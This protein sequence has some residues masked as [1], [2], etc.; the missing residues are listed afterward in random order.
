MGKPRAASARLPK[1][2]TYGSVGANCETNIGGGGILDGIIVKSYASASTDAQTASATQQQQ[3]LPPQQPM[4]TSSSMVPG[5]AA[6]R[7]PVTAQIGGTRSV[8]LHA[9]MRDLLVGCRVGGDP[10]TYLHA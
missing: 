5:G 4:N 10:L 6:H 1:N 8:T 9:C 7:R 3:P 2:E